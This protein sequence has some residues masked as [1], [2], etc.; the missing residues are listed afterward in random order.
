MAVLPGRVQHDRKVRADVPTERDRRD[1]RVRAFG[2]GDGDIPAQRL[3]VVGSFVLEPAG[4][5]HIATDAN[6]TSL[7]SN[8]QWHNVCP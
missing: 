6:I 7:I 8:S 1:F 4:I 5:I 3:E 2:K